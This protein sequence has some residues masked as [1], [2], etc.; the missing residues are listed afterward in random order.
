MAE[1]TWKALV[2]ASWA[3]YI[4]LVFLLA[5]LIASDQG[6]FNSVPQQNTRHLEQIEKR[7][8]ELEKNRSAHWAEFE[9]FRRHIE[10]GET[11]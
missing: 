9:K 10:A 8:D 11:K 1:I 4:I 5:W 3:P 6:A 2:R 7:L